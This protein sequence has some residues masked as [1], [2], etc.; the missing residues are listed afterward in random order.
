MILDGNNRGPRRI[1]EESR[2]DR[3]DTG[4]KRPEAETELK[5]NRGRN[6]VIQMTRGRAIWGR[7][8]QGRKKPGD[9]MTRG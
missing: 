5:T 1:V 6:D 3:N 8:D 4:S 2:L 9:E 7:I